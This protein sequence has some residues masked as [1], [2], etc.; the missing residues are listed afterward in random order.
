MFD[1]LYVDFRCGAVNAE[2]AFDKLADQ[3]EAG[4]IG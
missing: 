1:I 4:F 3:Y 2:S